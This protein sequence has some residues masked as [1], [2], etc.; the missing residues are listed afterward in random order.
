MDQKRVTHLLYDLPF[1]GVGLLGFAAYF[2]TGVVLG[3]L[4][5]SSLWWTVRMFADGGGALTIIT[6]TIARFVLVGGVL[7]LASLGGAMPLLLV[8]VG[9]P[10]GRFLVARRLRKNVS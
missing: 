1:D 6:S 10:A 2:T 7:A 5:F 9:I 4:H 3:V 8:A